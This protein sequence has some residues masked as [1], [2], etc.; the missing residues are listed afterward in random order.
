MATACSGPNLA[1]A[2]GKDLA[3]DF[4]MDCRFAELL[5]I[6]GL[7]GYYDRSALRVNKAQASPEEIR[8]KIKMASK[9]EANDF[10]KARQPQQGKLASLRARL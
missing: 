10:K 8:E 1:R 2:G 9:E 5:G 7:V 4:A 3:F 6:S